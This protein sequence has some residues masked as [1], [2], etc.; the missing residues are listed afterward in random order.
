MFE[1]EMARARQSW[2]ENTLKAEIA[3]AEERE[4]RDEIKGAEHLWLLAEKR[5]DFTN[6]VYSVDRMAG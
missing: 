5:W 4:Q 3:E 1:A 6:L 2:R